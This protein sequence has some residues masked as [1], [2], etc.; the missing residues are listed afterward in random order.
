VDGFD[1]GR[2]EPGQDAADDVDLFEVVDD[3]RGAD[4]AADVLARGRVRDDANGR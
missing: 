3:R 1:A 4:Q 2:G